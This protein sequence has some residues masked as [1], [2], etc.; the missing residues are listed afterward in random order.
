MSLK[1][2]QNDRRATNQTEP[3]RGLTAQANRE[4]IRIHQ[5]NIPKWPMCKGL[6]RTLLSVADFNTKDGMEWK[7]GKMELFRKLVTSISDHVNFLHQ[8]YRIYEPRYYT[9]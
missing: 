6:L 3:V 1:C 5:N 2:A 7:I 9:D 4:K 8:R